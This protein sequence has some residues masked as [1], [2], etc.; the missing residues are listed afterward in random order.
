MIINGVTLPDIPEEVLAQY[1]YAVISSVTMYTPSADYTQ[2]MYM[3]SVAD[4]PFDRIPK[5]LINADMGSLA[6]KGTGC[7][8]IW[9][10]GDETW[11]IGLSEA[12]EMPIVPDGGSMDQGPSTYTYEFLWTNQEEIKTAVWIDFN[13]GEWGTESGE[14]NPERVSIAL[15]LMNGFAY[16]TQRLTGTTEKVNAVQL[17]S[18]LVA[19]NSGGIGEEDSSEVELGTSRVSIGYD[20]L[21]DIVNEVQRLT[22]TTEKMNPITAYKKL[23]S[24]VPSISKGILLPNGVTLPGVPV[25]DWTDCK[26]WVAFCATDDLGASNPSYEGYSV[27]KLIGSTEGLAYAPEGVSTYAN[28]TVYPVGNSTY[29]VSFDILIGPDRTVSERFRDEMSNWGCSEVTGNIVWSNHDVMLM[30]G[31]PPTA[32]NQVYFAATE[33][34]YSPGA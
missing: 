14:E 12:A 22:G 28:P 30:A 17:R 5:E 2:V 9:F 29:N 25:D 4:V 18:L 33:P 1:P 3:L 27:Y 24:V 10:A 20:L 34:D 19:A 31:S 6:S 16:E 32:S 7:S 13:T 23:K 8:G 11:D 15:N 21:D 26:Y